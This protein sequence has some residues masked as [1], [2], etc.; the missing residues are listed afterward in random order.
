MNI[1]DINEKLD[2]LKD[3]DIKVV[4]ELARLEK[5]F[6]FLFNLK[7]GDIINL[8]KSIESFVNIYFCEELAGFGELVNV[9][10]KYG[11]RLIDLIK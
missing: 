3:I 5:N 10:E 1:E 9:N 7:E 6:E 8:E 2:L 4:I 11:V